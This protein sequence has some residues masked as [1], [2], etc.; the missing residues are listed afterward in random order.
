MQHEMDPLSPADLAMEMALLPEK[1]IGGPTPGD[2]LVFDGMTTAAKRGDVWTGYEWVSPARYEELREVMNL[3]PIQPVPGEGPGAEDGP[4]APGYAERAAPRCTCPSDDGSLTWPCPTHPPG[5]VHQPDHPARE[6]HPMEEYAQEVHPSERSAKAGD[7]GYS[8]RVNMAEVEARAM[9]HMLADPEHVIQAL[10]ATVI[11]ENPT[12][13]GLMETPRRVVEAWN[14]WTSGYHKKA[15]DILKVFEDGAEGCDEMVVVKDIPIYSHCEHHLAPIF[16][17]A[18]IGYLPNGKIVGL[19][20]LNRL[21]DMFAR[22]LQ[23][24]ERMTNQIADAL[25]QHLEPL[26]CGVVINAR[27]MCMESRGVCQSSHTVTS[28]LRGNFKDNPTV[29]A[30]FLALAR[31]GGK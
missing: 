30:E 14:Q 20:K 25:M 10:L 21:A 18:T 11:G 5:N 12:R 8:Y 13:G 1:R 24:Q 9:A 17:T 7:G 26:G 15:A 19:S 2:V 3:P 6:R 4:W 31:E 22:R 28:A 23:V 27:H 16:G 29:R